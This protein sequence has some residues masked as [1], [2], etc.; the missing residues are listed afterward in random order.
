M[1]DDCRFQRMGVPAIPSSLYPM[2]RGHPSRLPVRLAPRGLDGAWPRCQDL[3][4]IGGNGRLCPG[5]IASLHPF[6][7]QSKKSVDNRAGFHTCGWKRG[8]RRKAE[9]TPAAE[10]EDI[11]VSPGTL[12]MERAFPKTLLRRKNIAKRGGTRLPL[13]GNEG[14]KKTRQKPR[15][16]R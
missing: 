16:F 13:V 3:L 14:G 4:L 10:F 2:H 6:S 12:R 1:D 5:Q 8:E 15:V 11:V 9:S 7:Q